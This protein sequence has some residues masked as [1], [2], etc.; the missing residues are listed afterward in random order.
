MTTEPELMWALLLG[1]LLIL[2]LVVFII[3]LCMMYSK[4]FRRG[5][6]WAEN[7][8]IC[9]SLNFIQEQGLLNEY[10]Q[11]ECNRAL[12]KAQIIK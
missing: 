9:N 10:K 6:K 2:M 12:K 3:V 4:S 11:F 1:T 7:N 8:T 5:V